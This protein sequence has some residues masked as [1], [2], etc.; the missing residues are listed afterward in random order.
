M[1]TV[2]HLAFLN[3]GLNPLT[4]CSM[5]AKSHQLC[6]TLLWPAHFSCLTTSPSNCILFMGTCIPFSFVFFSQFSRK[7]LTKM[8]KLM[9]Q[10]NIFCLIVWIY[11]HDDR[12]NEYD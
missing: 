9:D 11:F 3:D 1:E 12:S 10:R 2:S 8:R 7:T 4:T 6:K 5:M